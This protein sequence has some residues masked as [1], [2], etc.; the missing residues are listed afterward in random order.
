[1]PLAIEH[2]L[3]SPASIQLEVTNTARAI[4]NNNNIVEIFRYP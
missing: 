3:A 1:M 4:R 2:R